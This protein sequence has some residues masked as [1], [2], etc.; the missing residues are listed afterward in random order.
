MAAANPWDGDGA[1]AETLERLLPPELLGG[2]SGECR[3]WGEAVAGP[4]DALALRAER[5]PAPEAA[6]WPV[7][8]LP[9]A[10]GELLAATARW[11]LAAIPSEERLGPWARIHQLALLMLAP[12]GSPRLVVSHTDAVARV[13]LAHDP[14]L[15]ARSVPR[16]ISREAAAAWHA[17]LWL[18][19]AAATG[20]AGDTRTA[21]RAGPGGGFRLRG[22][23]GN[24]P[25]HGRIALTLAR[26]EGASPGIR[27][28]SA[29]LIGAGAGVLV[30][31]VEN[32][33][34]D[35]AWAT[36]RVALE[37]AAAERV[38]DLGDG[39]EKL[40]PGRRVVELHH[41]AWACG[42]AARLVAALGAASHRS[43]PLRRASLAGIQV[44]REAGLAL[45]FECARLLG[46]QETGEA[47]ES[48][49]RLQ[50]LL[51]PLARLLAVRQASAIAAEVAEGLGSESGL[52]ET[53]L[54]RLLR[55]VRRLAGTTEAGDAVC[56]GFLHQAR[57][58]D[59]LELVLEALR[60]RIHQLGQGPLAD[61]A[62]P[63]ARRLE[64]FA[65]GY[66][67]TLAASG[68]V[69]EASAR[70]L[71]YGFAAL[72]A[73]VP[74]AEQAAWSLA[75]DRSGR[76]AAAVRRWIAARIP[77]LPD[78]AASDARLEADALL[79]GSTAPAPRLAPAEAPE[80]RGPPRG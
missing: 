24:A 17:A 73:A 41:T 18:Q 4:I 26:P 66:R 9:G 51:A 38:G 53:G 6:S 14:V 58:E 68:V 35:G 72:A 49:R 21:A 80:R 23:C 15:A 46:L 37:D 12:P 10:A 79:G 74:L 76:S 27:G 55:D 34:L 78:P 13:L 32:R 77:R 50:E 71:A 22:A 48:E 3:A 40:A 33:P 44:E 65:G 67:R 60:E 63:L 69:A 47:S 39:A 75:S 64:G 1:L 7:A 11:G 30:D 52:E 20:E 59:R 8:R 16:L 19:D 29:F 54:P 28:L 2:L 36:A 56:L 5:Q 62:E 61:L 70:G 45:A 57:R 42:L 43:S 31:R 25:L